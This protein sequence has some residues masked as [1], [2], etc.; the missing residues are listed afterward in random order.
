[1]DTVRDL[2]SAVLDAQ[3]HA[4]AARQVQYELMRRNDDIEKELQALKDL[5]AEKERYE[6]IN[7]SDRGAY[8]YAPKRGAMPEVTPHWLCQPCFDSSRKSLL[9]FMSVVPHQ[10]TRDGIALWRCPVC[11]E[12]VRARPNVRP[13]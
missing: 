13:I 1:M 8:V 5:S 11:N 4:L 2:N 7:V 6:I 10:Q 9:Q 3:D 12:N